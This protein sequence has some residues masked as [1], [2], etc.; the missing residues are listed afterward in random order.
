MYKVLN[1]IYKKSELSFALLWIITYCVLNSIGNIL[2]DLIGVNSSI[3]FIINAALT[4]VILIWI[5]KNELSKKYGLCKS[6]VPSSNFLWYIPLL[7]FVSHN[8]WLGVTI[9]LPIIDIVC[10][11]LNMIGVGFLE[12]I[13]FR[14]FL[15]KAL[16]KDNIKMAMIISSITFGVGHILNLFNGSGMGLVANMCQIVGAMACGFLFVIMFHR[17][18]T[19]LPCIMAHIVNNVI[20][21]FANEAAMTN[22]KLITI[23]V[24]NLI[25]IIIYI[26]ILRKTLPKEKI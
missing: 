17:G 5:R 22:Q 10:Y 8:V 26:L 15:F 16:A 19:L 11:I 25:V 2:S 20:N 23:S 21:I 1:K 7:V 14:G 9:N 3:T 18:G 4:I 6:E 24:I 13:I 12:E